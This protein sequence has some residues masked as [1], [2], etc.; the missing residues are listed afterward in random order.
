MVAQ[1]FDESAELFRRSLRSE[2]AVGEQALTHYLLAGVLEYAG[3]TD[4]ALVAAREAARLRPTSPHY[5]S[6]VIW[7]L[8][9][10]QRNEQAKSLYRQFIKKHDPSYESE[11][12]REIVKDAR[13]VMSNLCVATDDFD[14]AERWLEEVLDE[15]PD[16]IGALNDLGYLWADRGKHLKRSL[17]M[18]RRA[19]EAEP[20][21]TAY[22]DSLGWALFRL[23]RFENAAVELEKASQGEPDGVILDHLADAYHG[24]NRPAKALTTWRRA[25]KIF[26]KQGDQ[27]NRKGVELKIKRLQA[28]PVKGKP[29]SK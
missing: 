24:A 22:R 28:S 4:A 11:S 19:V 26:E 5:A 8:Y 25:A 14:E 2:P 20:D 9:H 12:I 17:A 23:G 3:K 7:V 13:I 29:R 1:R 15:F 27:E 6:R 18:V 21:N 10:A 16:D